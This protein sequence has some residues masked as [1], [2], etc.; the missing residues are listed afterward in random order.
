MRHHSVQGSTSILH[1]EALEHRSHRVCGGI[2]A[3]ESGLR[4][5]VQGRALHGLQPCDVADIVELSP[6]LP[7]AETCIFTCL[8]PLLYE[9]RRHPRLLG[10]RQHRRRS[11]VGRGREA[12]RRPSQVDPVGPGVHVK[13][14]VARGLESPRADARHR[15]RPMGRAATFWS[16]Q[17][18]RAGEHRPLTAHIGLEPPDHGVAAHRLGIVSPLAAA[19]GEAKVALLERPCKLPLWCIEVKREDLHRLGYRRPL[20]A[21]VQVHGNPLAG[22]RASSKPERL[23][24]AEV[25]TCHAGEPEVHKRGPDAQSAGHEATSS[26]E[27]VA[28]GV[29]RKGHDLLAQAARVEE[30]RDDDVEALLLALALELPEVRAPNEGLAEPSRACPGSVARQDTPRTARQVRRDLDAHHFVGTGPQRERGQDTDATTEICHAAAAASSAQRRCRHRAGLHLR[31]TGE[32]LGVPSVPG[33]GNSLADALLEDEVPRGIVHH[34][35]IP[36]EQ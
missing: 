14:E 4:R 35:R 33:L 19:Q 31:A 23:K 29:P 20:H 13:F 17:R 6:Q 7:Q 10:A 36:L 9:V 27:Q 3:Q 8:P 16:E 15:L 18:W 30:L 26:P 12:Q 24:R 11:V 2:E 34:L 25:H 28:P 21:A 1:V 5:D 22:R 32:G